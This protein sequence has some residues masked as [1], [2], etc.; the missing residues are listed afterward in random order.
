[1]RVIMACGHRTAIEAFRLIEHV[2]TAG[3]PIGRRPRPTAL[4]NFTGAEANFW[5]CVS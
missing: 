4:A 2:A 1:M 5:R 3:K